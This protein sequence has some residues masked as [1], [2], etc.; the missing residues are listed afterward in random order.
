MKS[1]ILL[2][3]AILFFLPS[4]LTASRGGGGMG[5][6]DGTFWGADLNRNNCLDREEAKAVHN[7]AEDEIFNRYDKDGNGCINRVEFGEF[8][9]QAP[10]TKQFIPP[11]EGQ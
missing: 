6:V 11:G 3:L 4:N 10:W 5:L 2:F 1:F 7:L 9:Q 8:M